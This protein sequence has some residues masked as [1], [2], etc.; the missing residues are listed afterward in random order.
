MLVLCTR[1]GVVIHVIGC[2]ILYYIPHE[3]VESTGH[4]SPQFWLAALNK[5]LKGTQERGVDDGALVSQTT[6][7]VHP[8]PVND[9][10]E[11]NW[12]QFS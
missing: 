10:E 3:C 2:S 5:G 11:G 8:V 9:V 4:A 1:L 6:V 7:L 12:C